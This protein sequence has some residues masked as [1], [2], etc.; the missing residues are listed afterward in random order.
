MGVNVGVL[1][2]VCVNVGVSVG[3]LVTVCVN[4]GVSVGVSVGVLVTVCVN[5]GVGVGSVMVNTCVAVCLVVVMVAEVIV[6]NNIQL[7]LSDD[8]YKFQPTGSLGSASFAVT[9]SYASNVIL[10]VL[11]INKLDD[12]SVPGAT[13][14]PVR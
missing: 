7:I 12:P 2:T 3:V 1:V 11:S 13:L 4:V 10:A 5:V 6:S 8:P 9:Q 14:P